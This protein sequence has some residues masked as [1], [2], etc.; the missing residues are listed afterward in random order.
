MWSISRQ[1]DARKSN[2]SISSATHLHSIPYIILDA[3]CTLKNWQVASLIYCIKPNKQ[4]T[5]IKLMNWLGPKN[6]KKTPTVCSGSLVSNNDIT[7]FSSYYFFVLINEFESFSKIFQP[8]LFMPSWNKQTV[9]GHMQ[10][11][12]PTTSLENDP[13]QLYMMTLQTFGSSQTSSV[14]VVI[15]E[16]KSTF[17]K[18]VKVMQY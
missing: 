5:K 10:C 6:P 14:A 3:L 7:F 18:T 4:L 11:S 16:L 1:N 13:I 17:N 15:M 9:I 2:G 8:H 12:I